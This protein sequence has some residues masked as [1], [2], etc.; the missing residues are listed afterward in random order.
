MKIRRL[1]ASH[2]WVE[3]TRF[4]ETT[5]I[6]L[7]EGCSW[8]MLA[9][10]CNFFSLSW[11]LHLMTSSWSPKCFRLSNSGLNSSSHKGHLFVFFRSVIIVRKGY[12]QISFMF[13]FHMVSQI[14]ICS[15]MNATRAQKICFFMCPCVYFKLLNVL[16]CFT[17]QNSIIVYI[18]R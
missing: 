11:H 6:F 15:E 17:T 3:W 4:E 12:V 8:W 16:K 2:E 9:I 10:C 5:C 14:Y 1:L 13:C 7:M 18:F